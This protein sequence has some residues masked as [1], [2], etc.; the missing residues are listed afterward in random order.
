MPDHAL[1]TAVDAYLADR[2]IVNDPALDA[3]AAAA[4]AAGL[5]DI[6]VSPVLGKYLYL[7][8]KLI[9]ARRILEIGTLGG[10]STIWL[11]R[12]LPGDGHLVTLE[13]EP[14]HAGVARAN[15]DRA[16]VGQ[17][18]QIVLGKALASLRDIADRDDPPFDMV[19]IDADKEN[20]TAYLDWSIRL[21]R[22]GGLIVADNVVRGGNVLDTAS[23]DSMV[24]G[25]QAFNDALAKDARVE[26]IALQTVSVK[27]YDG[28]AMAM[29]KL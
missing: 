27:G 17:Q 15:I 4:K 1:F 12:A 26:A 18:V 10:Y 13:Y 16:A 28:F 25:V 8:A 7:L 22:P 6:A 9:S 5:P 23:T 21:T 24:Q 11:A 20:Y 14:K 2:F 29:V 3:A 19:F